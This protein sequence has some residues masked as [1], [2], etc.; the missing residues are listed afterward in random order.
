[1][2]VTVLVIVNYDKEEKTKVSNFNQSFLCQNGGRLKLVSNFNE[3]YFCDIQRQQIKSN[4]STTFSISRLQAPLLIF[5]SQTH[6]QTYCT[7]KEN[8]KSEISLKEKS[9]GCEQDV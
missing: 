4:S 2:S 6:D 5:H 7:N 9:S 3:K 8:E 1:M